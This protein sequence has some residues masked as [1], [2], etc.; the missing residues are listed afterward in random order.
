MGEEFGHEV[1]PLAARDIDDRLVGVLP[2]IHL[3]SRIFGRYLLSMPF[4]NDGGPLGKEEASHALVE[5]G[6][7]RAADL[8]VDLFELRTRERLPI[9]RTVSTRKVSVLLDLPDDPVHFWE[10]GIR[11]KVRSQIRRPMKEGMEIRFG[12]DQ[13]PAFYDVFSRNMRDLGTPVL[14]RSFFE[15][16]VRNLPDR[17]RIG[18]VWLGEVPVAG[19]W[20]L[21]EGGEFEMTWASA[22]REYNRL[23]PNMLLYWGFMERCIEEGIERF[24]FGRST[25]GSGPHRFKLQ[26]GGRDHPL[27]WLQ[28]S[29]K[30]VDA[31]PSPDSPT[32]RL[33]TRVWSRLPVAI[34]NR[35]GPILARQ[36]P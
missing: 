32:F 22:L 29:P 17:F 23:S 2:L 31:T 16:I 5:E 27:P 4:L 13:L 18:A 26:W 24:N 30:G 3:R 8:Q 19:G 20:G 33:A 1:L 25:P 34:T 9:E 11:A 12:T 7:R 14:P 6:I 35:V 21:V 28:W 10:K 15:S 36:I